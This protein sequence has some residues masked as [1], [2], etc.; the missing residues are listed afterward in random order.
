MSL[1]TSLLL[2]AASPVPIVSA[3]A[4]CRR[5]QHFG[6]VNIRY[7]VSLLENLISRN[8][9]GNLTR[10]SSLTSF[11]IRD[12]SS[13]ATDAESLSKIP[14]SPFKNIPQV[15]A[16]LMHSTVWD[17]AV[18]TVFGIGGLGDEFSHLIGKYLSFTEFYLIIECLFL[19]LQKYLLPYMLHGLGTL[20][21]C[22][23]LEHTS[24]I[25]HSLRMEITYLVNICTFTE[26]TD[27]V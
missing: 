19:F 23:C 3:L 20:A 27:L 4:H 24:Q 9:V 7:L 15:L 18:P 8:Y 6:C 25:F 26:F 17:P 14:E 11:L 5:A 21:C 1:K 16:T 13:C 22:V 2:K 12:N 10:A